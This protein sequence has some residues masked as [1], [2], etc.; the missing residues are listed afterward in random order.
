MMWRRIAAVA[1]VL[2]L[3]VSGTVLAVTDAERKAQIDSKLSEANSALA[4]A[5]AREAVQ[6]EQVE[7]AHN[8]VKTVAAR[9][10]PLE[11][12]LSGLERELRE[13]RTQLQRLENRLLI[14]R[15]RL[16]KAQDDLRARRVVL[17][18]RLRDLYV[19]PEPDP[20]LVLLE[21]GSISDALEVNE[22]IELT[23][24]QDRS[25]VITIRE[26][27]A[28]VRATREKI[29]GVRDNVSA[30]EKRVRSATAEAR[31]A[32][33]KVR[34]EKAAY[35]KA[36]AA[37]RTLL[38]SASASREDA[39][40]HAAILQ[41]ESDALR[42]KILAATQATTGASA[43]VGPASSAG[44]VWPA[45]G[46]LTSHFGWRWGRAHEGIDVANGIGTPIVAAASGTVI[47]A[48]WQGGYGNMVVVS[49]G[50]GI[51][52]G[53]AHLS[54][55]GVGVGQ[56]VGQG[57]VIGGMGSTGN[58]TGSHLHFEVRVNG[59]AVNPLGYL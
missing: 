47:I 6:V 52:T 15:K 17:G 40:I 16:E 22:L 32:A 54:S 3:G 24:E 30:S 29:A 37:R 12:R 50:N 19:S 33:E 9:L 41:E 1:V 34:V 38:Q 25:M 28:D 5:K 11:A 53:Y 13:L 23:A 39:E 45:A 26:R 18:Q 7:A 48:G 36:L 8:R 27:V 51:S 2:G 44:F 14:E 4:N 31:D 46:T 55:I 58:S 43:P 10:E 59:G 20:V 42:S 56:T 35:D 57:S 49:H 21:S